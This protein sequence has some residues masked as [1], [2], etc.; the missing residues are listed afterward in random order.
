[1]RDALYKW[2]QLDRDLDEESAWT[3]PIL[4]LFRSVMESTAAVVSK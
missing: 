2:E 3:E 4:A 1:M